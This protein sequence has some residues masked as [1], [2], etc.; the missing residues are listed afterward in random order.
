MRTILAFILVLTGVATHAQIHFEAGYFIT[1]AN[2]K[3]VCEIKNAEWRGNPTEFD[4]RASE[5][6]EVKTASIKDVKEFAIGNVA[7]YIRYTVQ[8]DRSSESV[9]DLSIDKNPVFKEEELFLKVL[10]EGDASLYEYLGRNLRRYFYSKQNSA[11][12]QLVFK[13]YFTADTKIGQNNYFRQQLWNDLKCP[14]ITLSQIEG[15]KYHSN[16]LLRFFVDYNECNNSTMTYVQQ[17]PKRDA[18]NLSVQAHLRSSSS[19]ITNSANDDYSFN[20]DPKLSVSAGLEAEFVLPF[21]K[22]K[23]SIFI[24]PTYHSFEGNETRVAATVSGHIIHATLEYKSIE[25]PVGARY[26]FFLSDKSKLFLNAAYVFDFQT[27]N[28]MAY[29]RDNGT[30][31]AAF[32]GKSRG[33]FAIGGGYKYDNKVSLEARLMTPRDLLPDFVVYSAKYHSVSVIVGYTFL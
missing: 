29:T 5:T 12:T 30:V 17:K 24:A 23:W 10:V 8:I 28:S 26:Y 15:L 9:N 20:F 13:S 14:Q 21:N 16:D 27:K 22:N 7:K 18:F 6:D 19:E 33:N 1:S 2:Q 32:A 11:P 4:Y 3:V 25:V 31:L